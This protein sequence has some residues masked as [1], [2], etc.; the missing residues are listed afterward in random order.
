MGNA[1]ACLPGYDLI[2]EKL[3]QKLHFSQLRPI[4]IYSA[5]TILAPFVFILLT[6]LMKQPPCVHVAFQLR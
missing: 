6:T 2:L 5:V 3:N 1:G 4:G